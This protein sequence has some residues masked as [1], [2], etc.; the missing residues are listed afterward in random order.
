MKNKHSMSFHV[1]GIFS[2]LWQS[3]RTVEFEF[4]LI[5]SLTL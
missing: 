2:I 3:S 4:R 5:L 1:V